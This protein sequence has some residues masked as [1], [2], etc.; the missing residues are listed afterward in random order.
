MGESAGLLLTANAVIAQSR[1]VIYLQ[2]FKS[3]FLV[4]K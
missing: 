3:F 1:W 2:I 4:E